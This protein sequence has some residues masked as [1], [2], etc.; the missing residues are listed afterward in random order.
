MTTTPSSSSSRSASPAGAPRP[1]LDLSVYLVADLDVCRE[2][3]VP[4]PQ[5]V[6]RSVAGGATVVQLR[7]KDLPGGAFTELAAEV[8]SVLPQT[9]PL[10]I[11][12]RIDVALALRARGLPCGGVHV[13]QSDLHVQDARALLGTDAVIG[14][15]ASQ[16][17]QIQAAQASPARVDYV[18][19]GPL[20]STRTK[21]DAPAG[22]GI[23]TVIERARD[24]SLPAVAIGGITPEDMGA[25][26]SG[27][28]KGAAVVSYICASDDP[29]AATARLAA[30]WKES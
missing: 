21:R 20:H 14:L 24:C 12:D 17:E 19:I 30:A 27:G 15:S 25:L 6:A 10:L 5:V 8:S 16:P 2:A 18:G 7:A 23:G 26:R 28:L 13:G 11:N 4:L 9:V 3:G 22:L 1:P 29:E